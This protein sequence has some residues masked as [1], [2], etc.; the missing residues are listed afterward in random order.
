M[1]VSSL[2][3]QLAESKKLPVDWL[4]PVLWAEGDHIGMRYYN[5]D[6]QPARPR[7]RHSDGDH[8]FAW[9]TCSNAFYR[10][11][12]VEDLARLPY[13]LWVNPKL[14]VDYCILGEGES[15]G[16][17]CW[18]HDRPYLGIP[19]WANYA[20]LKL[21]H[22]HQF[23]TLYIHVEPDKGGT[24]FAQALPRHLRDIGYKGR[25]RRFDLSAYGVKDPSA[26]H[27]DAPERFL[28]RLQTAFDAATVAR[29]QPRPKP[30]S[31]KITDRLSLESGLAGVDLESLIVADIGEPERGKWICPYHDDKSPSLNVFVGRDGKQRFKCFGC[32]ETGD[33]IKWLRAY[34]GLGFSDACRLL[35]IPESHT[36]GGAKLRVTVSKKERD[37][38]SGPLK[39]IAPLDT[40]TRSLSPPE[41]A[42]TEK[43]RL[44]RCPN[45]KQ[46]VL[47]EREGRK[48]VAKLTIPCQRRRCLFCREQWASRLADHYATVLREHGPPLTFLVVPISLWGQTQRRLGQYVGIRNHLDQRLVITD[49]DV[50][51]VAV[52]VKKAVQLISNAIR[53]A[54]ETVKKPVLASRDWHHPKETPGSNRYQLVCPTTASE[55]R[56]IRRCDEL[57]IPVGHAEWKRGIQVL[58]LGF[59]ATWDAERIWRFFTD[60]EVFELKCA[61]RYKPLLRE[62]L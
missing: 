17:A 13:G 1:P 9:A 56:V 31:P 37:R 34:R 14:D 24:A 58:Q 28:E 8:R 25:I 57:A 27:I 35:G 41:V 48:Q 22:I 4:K 59:P 46:V 50:G 30:R 7:I 12:P 44:R 3:D 10:G 36:Y 39:P 42:I 18:L 61:W 15:D 20:I 51:G 43:P 53:A 33:A 62:P 11:G 52:S 38:A 60:C 6:G 49:S 19:G 5:A 32:G 45:A 55:E 16:W 2:I 29:A 54:D 26:L 47:Q 21:E 40:V 23:S